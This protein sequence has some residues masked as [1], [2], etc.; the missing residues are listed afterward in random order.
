[1]T[2]PGSSSH[3]APQSPQKTT[4]VKPRLPFNR[5]DLESLSKPKVLISG[6]GIGGLTLAILLHKA[7]IPFLVLERAKEIKP[8]GAAFM[9]GTNIAPLLQQLDMYDDFLE[10]AKLGTVMELFNEELQ[11]LFNIDTEIGGRL[12]GSQQ[13]IISRPSFYGLLL[14]RI[15]REAVLLGKRVLSFSQDDSGVVVR[16]SDNSSYTGDILVGADGAYSAVRQQLYKDLKLKSKLP[17]SDDVSLP[18][19][20]VCLVGQT[21]PLNPEEFPSLKSE[22]S[23]F[24]AVLGQST[25]CT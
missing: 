15:P 13:H 17:H 21:V 3:S 14:S 1:M 23:E 6:G 22:R 24:S 7:D 16:C 9:I 20:C 10:S 2:A 12:G 19:N 4:P 25:M 8:L 5:E 11:P 18:F